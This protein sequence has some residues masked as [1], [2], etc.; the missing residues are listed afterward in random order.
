MNG[1]SPTRWR[2]GTG[3][4]K[5][6]WWESQLDTWLGQVTCNLADSPLTLRV[7]AFERWRLSRG[8]KSAACCQ[9]RERERLDCWERVRES[10]GEK[11]AIAR[12]CA[13]LSS[14]NF[15]KN[16]RVCFG[17][18]VGYFQCSGGCLLLGVY[19]LYKMHQRLRMKQQKTEEIVYLYYLE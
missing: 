2:W 9:Q 1:A 15:C 8:D 18:V 17:K 16:I 5:S 11:V 13:S 3:G 10:F 6:V 12:G 4:D 19:F 14:P 7:K